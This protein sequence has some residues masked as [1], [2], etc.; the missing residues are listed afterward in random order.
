MF[1]QAI[2]DLE[3]QLISANDGLVKIKQ[4][5]I[6][7]NGMV[8]EWESKMNDWL[9]KAKQLDDKEVTE[10]YTQEKKDE[11]IIEALNK[12]ENAKDELAK[13][14]ANYKK[15]QVQVKKVQDK[16]TEL[17][18]TIKD[19]KQEAAVVKA[20]AEAAK[21]RKDVNKTLSDLG[22]SDSAK[23]M[24]DKMRAKVEENDALADAYEELDTDTTEDEI[25]K[26]LSASSKTKNEDLLANFR[27]KGDV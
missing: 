22:G 17:K 2:K 12:A 18:E 1:D 15:T 14:K 27:N 10:S 25:E 13:A 11:L 24:M 19:A 8:S 20:N 6:K 21:A 3:G 7:Q 5:E 26:A 23:A 9:K 4:I 16:V